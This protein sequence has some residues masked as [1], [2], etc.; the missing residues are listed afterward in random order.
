M[1]LTVNFCDNCGRA[2]RKKTD[3]EL[4]KRAVVLVAGTLDIPD[5]L[6]QAKPELELY[7]NYRVSRLP[8]YATAI[9]KP[10]F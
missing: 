4:F 3:H 7:T 9:Q 5:E 8:K 6:E 1:K 10:E 2:V